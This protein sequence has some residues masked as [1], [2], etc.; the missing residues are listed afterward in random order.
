MDMAVLCHRCGANLETSDIFC[1]DCGSPQIRFDALTEEAPLGVQA[2]QLQSRG[3]GIFWKAAIQASLWVGV[4][5]GIL[6]AVTV[7]SR[8]C[9]L[10]VTGGAMVAILLYHQRAP[11]SHIGPKQG[12]RIGAVAGII[13]AYSAVAATAISRVIERFVLHRGSEIDHFYDAILK[14]LYDSMLHQSMTLMQSNPEAQAQWHNYA[15]FLLTPD[16]RAAFTLMNSV[17]SSIGIVIF[18]AIGGVLGVKL[19]AQGKGRLRGL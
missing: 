18:S 7:L 3:Q 17:T 14:Q 10:W 9:C 15:H 4:P 13:A 1:P 16:G 19:F 12:L 5:A 6:S 2:R 8:G 11:D